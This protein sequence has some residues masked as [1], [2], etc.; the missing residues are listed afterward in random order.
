M[1]CGS[2]NH[3]LIKTCAQGDRFHPAHDA[4]SILPLIDGLVGAVQRGLLLR[5]VPRAGWHPDSEI[6]VLPNVS[7]APGTALQVGQ[8]SGIVLDPGNGL[9]FGVIGVPV[10]NAVSRVVGSIPDEV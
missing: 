9:L 4:I 1:K 7:G 8:Y 3:V 5:G 6:D 2:V 10:V